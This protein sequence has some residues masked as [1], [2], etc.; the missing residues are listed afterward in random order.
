MDT[1]EETLD[2]QGVA[3]LL[4]AEPETVALYARAGELPGTKMG[5]SWVFLREDVLEFL[6]KRIAV[7]TEERLGKRNAT[8]AA[9]RVDALLVERKRQSR[10]TNLPVLPNAGST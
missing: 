3:A 7:E 2:L 6:R 10:R 9:S 5:K 4:K 1:A 8:L